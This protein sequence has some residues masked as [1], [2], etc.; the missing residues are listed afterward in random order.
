MYCPVCGDFLLEMFRPQHRCS[1]IFYVWNSDMSEEGARK[2]H[3]P[4]PQEAAVVWADRDDASSADYSIARGNEVIVNVRREGEGEV[5][6]FRVYGE[7][8][9]HYHAVALV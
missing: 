7:T 9:P 4:D 2:V 6:R 5:L 3:A 1:P 8:V